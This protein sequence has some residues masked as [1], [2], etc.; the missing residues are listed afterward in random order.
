V[1]ETVDR[2]LMDRAALDRGFSNGLAVSAVAHG[3]VVAVAIVGPLLFPHKAVLQ[4]QPGFVVPLPP[5][6]GGSPSAPAPAPPAPQPPKPEPPKPEPPPKV[7]KPPQEPPKKGVPALDSKK[8]KTTAKTTPTPPKAAGGGAAGS[9]GKS[10]QTPGLEFGLTPG[11]GVPGGTDPMGDWYLAGVQRKI[12]MLWTQ[13]IRGDMPQPV[14][15]RFTITADGA[16]EDVEI[17][18]SSGAYLLDNAAQR[19]VTTAAPFSPLPKTY[20]TNRITIQAVFKPTP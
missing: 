13:Q 12:W 4:I 3:F 8:R 9:T 18:Q 7:I 19:A 14:T 10:S 6:G 20:E 17:L 15:V 2:L 5:G 16:V 11:P 1:N